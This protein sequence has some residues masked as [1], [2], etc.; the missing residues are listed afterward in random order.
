MT[1]LTPEA[2]AKMVADMNAVSMIWVGAAEAAAALTADGET[3]ARLTAERDIAS[4][5]YCDLMNR[6]DA[7]FVRA[8][9]AEAR[10]KVLEEALIAAT[11]ELIYLREMM[12]GGHMGALWTAN[13]CKDLWRNK[14]INALKGAKP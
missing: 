7:E 3:I 10:V 4:K 5:E 13:D 14:A 9:A 2:R 8:E 6:H 11:A 1:A 12:R